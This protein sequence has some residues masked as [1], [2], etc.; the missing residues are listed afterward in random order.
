[1]E[2]DID[3]LSRKEPER[4]RNFKVAAVEGRE[5]EGTAEGRASEDSKMR[6]KRGERA[7]IR[8]E[9]RGSGGG[10]DTV[11]PRGIRE[12]DTRSFSPGDERRRRGVKRGRGG[13]GGKPKGELDIYIGDSRLCTRE[14]P[15]REKDA[16]RARAR[17]RRAERTVS[18]Y[19][20]VGKLFRILHPVIALPVSV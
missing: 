4:S 12:R 16:V 14:E 13:G 17:P 10:K 5:R 3:V 1:M 7:R 9:K 20:G 6:D 11:A 15:F 2:V 8:E 18:G 19:E